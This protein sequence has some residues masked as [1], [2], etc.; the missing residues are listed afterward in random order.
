[1]IPKDCKRLAEVDFPIAEVSRHAAREK[2]IR[3]GHPSTL[4]LWWARRPLASSR[5]VLLALLWPDPCDPLCPEAFKEQARELL[6]Q[7]QGK[8]G[9]TDEDLRKA[10]LKFIAD[11]ANW[12][13]AANRNYLEVSRAL[14]KAAH[15]PAPGSGRQ[16]AY[17]PPLVVD[18][19][20]GGG[21][22]P[23]EALRLG[24]EAFASDL[25]PVACLILKVMLED[26]PRHGPKLAQELRR[27][28]AEIKQQA[29]KEL[30]DFYPCLPAG[31]R[32]TPPAPE[33]G[34]F[35]AYVLKCSDGSFYKGHTDNLERRFKEHEGGMVDWTSTRLPVALWYFEALTSRDAAIARENYF[36]SGSGR[37][38]LERKFQEI[39]EQP[40]AYLWARTVRCESPNCGAEIPLVRS[41]WLCKKAKRRRALKHRVVRRAGEAPSVEFEVFEPK[42]EQDVS[43]GTVFKARATCISCSSVLA[44]ARVQAQLTAQQ[45]GASV[46][47]DPTGARVGGARL[48]A[49]VQR[50]TSTDERE[51]RGPIA[52]DYLALWRA[53]L[54]I[55][56]VEPTG[57]A[58]RLNPARP[59]PNAR[60]VTAPTR[61][62]A[63]TFR[64][65]FSPRQRLSLG[66]LARLIKQLSGSDVAEVLQDCLFLALGRCADQSSAHIAWIPGIEAVGHTFPRQAIQM[67]WDFVESVPIASESANYLAAV[68][69]IAK[70]VDAMAV[71]VK[72]P[73]SVNQADAGSLPL[74]T[75]SAGMVFTDP[76]YYDAVPYAD[77]SD[78]FIG[79]LSSSPSM[80]RFSSLNGGDGSAPKEQECV[81]NTAHSV[82]GHP[83][84]SDFFE[85]KARECLA[86]ARRVVGAHAIACVVF[87]HKTTEGWEALLS[88]MINGGWMIRASWPIVTERSVRTNAQN[89]ASL[90]TSV[91]LVC[92]PR[93]DDAVVGDWAD[94]LRELPNR[95][96]DWM[97]RLQGEGVRG[98]DLVFAC[99]GPALEI[100]SRYTK[101]E[102]A[103]G[104]E[105]TLA[106]YL[107]KV[108]E[109]VGRSAL[110][111]V[112]GTAEAKA[113]NGAAG[114]V[115]EDARLTALFLW[116]LQSTDQGKSEKEKGKSEDVIEEVAEDIEDDEEGGEPEG[117][118][119]GY[120]LVFDVVRRF[121]QP[122]GIDLPKWE[123]RIIETKKGVVRLFSIAERGRILF[124][125]DGVQAAAEQLEEM[126]SSSVTQLAL[127]PELAAGT[128]TKMKGRGKG[129]KRVS[130]D[131]SDEAL[132]TDREATI[133][134][135]VHAAM[136]LQAGGR[137]NALRALLKAE[138]ERG[139]DF[140]RL[141]NAFSALYP[142]GSE[143]K[144]LLDAM[145]LAVPR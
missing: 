43:P 88:G 54:A 120:T 119:K 44:P 82:N 87:A 21:S 112:L 78:F 79:W 105:V 67:V 22:I 99:I 104:R 121:A 76:P 64:D 118:A 73:G 56:A 108:W 58:I 9:P 12:D 136:L 91:H 80:R 24:C 75:E 131:V 134:D 103:D 127:F 106:E 110:A 70:V 137:T 95:V 86:E 96:G 19:F 138:Q 85:A 61:Y 109:V 142:N 51:Y 107:E 11:F 139:P 114:A 53:S 69:W 10:L 130:L 6:P 42:A 33:P 62:G 117:K 29:E 115:E 36:K 66:T 39:E 27:V 37:E 59:S 60:G 143:E 92:R 4:H 128:P 94:V 16:A 145:L 74:P 135:R 2:S 48:L 125:D 34:K 89:T 32:R 45:A 38:W 98:A 1:M 83:K 77:L 72:T 126:P 23:L 116:T 63:T 40:I 14:V 113:R 68:E 5:A 65:L 144:R 57:L 111:Q 13:L 46:L 93:A 41:F 8:V 26:I 100:F 132:K 31:R 122:L 47:F 50:S 18:P 25:N 52:Q 55:G 97:E 35:Y 20:A 140:L 102:T 17:E 129:G 81:W 15:L 3:H 71:A 133:L 123:G 7:V 28:G 124:G 49:I 84:T 141:A 30:A 90:G 101:V